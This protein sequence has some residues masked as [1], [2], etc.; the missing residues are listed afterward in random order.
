MVMNEAILFSVKLVYVTSYAIKPLLVI[1]IA[2]ISSI[3]INNIYNYLCYVPPC[4][5]SKN[6]D[7]GVY[8]FTK[9][10]T[11]ESTVTNET[12]LMTQLIHVMAASFC[13]TK[14]KDPE[15]FMNWV[16]GSK[17]AIN[18]SETT[19][20]LRMTIL[21]W[22]M[23]YIIKETF[24]KGNGGILYCRATDGSIGAASL[25]RLENTEWN[26]I[27]YN[28]MNFL[29][30]YLVL[31]DIGLPPWMSSKMKN[32]ITPGLSRRLDEGGKFLKKFHKKWCNGPHIYTLIMAT[33]PKYQGCG[34]CGK[35]M[36]TTVALGQEEEIDVYLETG[37]RKNQSIY[38]RYG[39]KL[40]EE[41][42]LI[43]KDDGNEPSLKYSA[44]LKK[45]SESNDTE[46]DT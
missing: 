3:F 32:E 27:L 23:M 41:D 44:M 38:E 46:K 26:S 36:R 31:F 8:L 10:G 19:F 11:T 14:S 17:L 28:C 7:Y 2:I 18:D 20:D 30:K 9:N 13:G 12:K 42:E 25:I 39:Y 24:Q 6:K 4:L 43:L 1:A 37:G 29:T 5:P 33:H 34:Y 22:T 45:Y 16:L 35:I 21:D 15:R 40:V